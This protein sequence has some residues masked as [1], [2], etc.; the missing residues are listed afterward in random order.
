MI[1]VLI[2]HAPSTQHV[3]V[4]EQ[5]LEKIGMM[6]TSMRSPFLRV[7]FHNT[8]QG[9]GENIGTIILNQNNA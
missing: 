2:H 9:E 4:H 8:Y 1:D 7:K 3:I 6:L 5:I